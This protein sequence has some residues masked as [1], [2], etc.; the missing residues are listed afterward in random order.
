MDELT[1]TG[2]RYQRRRRLLEETHDELVVQI[3]EARKTLTLRAIADRTGLSFARIHQ[4][5]KD[6]RG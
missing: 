3:L 1:R 6:H 4:I 2:R 5:E